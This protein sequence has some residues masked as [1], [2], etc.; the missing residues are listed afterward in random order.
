MSVLSRCRTSE[1][2]PEAQ[3]QALKSQ[4]SRSHSVLGFTPILDPQARNFGSPRPG[5]FGVF[6]GVFPS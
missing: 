4:K 3:Q 6:A 5:R 1:D 2:M